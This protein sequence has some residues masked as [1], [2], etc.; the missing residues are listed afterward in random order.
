MRRLPAILPV[1]FL[2]CLACG[3]SVLAPTSGPRPVV[4]GP[5]PVTTNGPIVDTFLQFRPRGPAT[6]AVGSVDL[7]ITS[8]YSSLFQNGSGNGADVVIDAELWRT[9]VALRTGVTERTDVEVEVPVIYASNGFADDLIEGWHSFFG[10]PDGGR[11]TRPN[12]SYDVHV[13]QNGQRAYEL[14]PYTVAIGDIPIVV[15]QRVADEKDAGVGLALRAGIELPVG[16]ESKGF[17][18]GGIDW[19]GGLLAE[20]SIERVTLTGAAYYVVT[21]SSSAFDRAGVDAL[22]AL[23]IHGGLEVRWNDNASIVF[24]LRSTPPATHD[25]DIPEVD[26]NVLDLDI[27]WIQDLGEGGSRLVLGFTEDLIA[28]S[29]PDLTVFL[30]WRTGF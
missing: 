20:R 5:L 18:N 21:A 11:N 8:E 15:T 26:S 17:G 12:N 28:D 25:V 19:G 6:T 9:G 24:G 10:L 14:E 22:D 4:R 3:C 7:A 13:D 23:E 16:S 1:C 2:A 27:G 29:G 30:G